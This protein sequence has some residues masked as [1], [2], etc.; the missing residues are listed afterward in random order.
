MRDDV[1]IAY[2][3][4][5]YEIG[6]GPGFYGIWA[7]S[8][9]R[10]QPLEW[11]P[12]T[13]EGWYA[14]WARFVAVEVPS[15]IATVAPSTG[16]TQPVRQ[17]ETQLEYFGAAAPQATPQSPAEP[18]TE[19]GESVDARVEPTGQPSVVTSQ[20]PQSSAGSRGAAVA[21]VALLAIGIACG[22]VGLFPTYL[23]STS[24]AQEPAELVPHV[25]YLATW[26]IGGLLILVGRNR[27]RIGALLATGTSVVTFGFFFADLGTPIASGAHLM[28][29]GLVVSLVGWLF[30]FAGSMVAL[31]KGPQGDLL[32][33]PTGPELAPFVALTLAALGAAAA[34]APS[35]DSYVLQTSAGATD[36]IT[37]GNIF[38]NPAAVIAGNVAVMVALVAVVVIAALW[39]PI[40]HG[41]IL[42]TGAIVPM[43][44]QA[45]SAVIQIGQPTPPSTFGISSSAAAQS[46]L[47][48]TSGL[49]L[50]FWIYCVF[51][52]ALMLMAASAVLAQRP[53][54]VAFSGAGASPANPYPTDPRPPF[55]AD[56]SSFDPLSQDET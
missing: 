54:R 40:V 39:R 55:G 29:P 44:A 13:P 20:L 48:I 33:K 21:A 4:A 22:I 1:T 49:A 14:A 28:G 25:I 6:R 53:G 11:W 38:S 37:A 3:G 50:A 34:F 35:W 24:L 18:A 52:V 23:S 9:A 8:E 43:V 2:R 12:E 51:V 47:T 7:R 27:L 42:L 41:A 15:T 36:T 17:P 16:Q 5:S 19:N 10:S 56:P 46:G 30:C 26:S 45:V 31:A 32:G